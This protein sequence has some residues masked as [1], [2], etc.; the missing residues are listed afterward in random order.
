MSQRGYDGHV[1][2]LVNLAASRQEGR[3]T[4]QRI[5]SV[6]REFLGVTV[7]DA[8]FIL[9]DP[10]VGQAV[11]SREPFVLAYPRCPASRCLAALATKLCAGGSL[12]ARKE[13]FFRRVARWFA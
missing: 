7:Y 9:T 4:H 10:R 8:G 6:A 13:G 11:R 5:A 12:V 1:S 2:L 3:T